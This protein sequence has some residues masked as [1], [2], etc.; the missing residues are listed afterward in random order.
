MKRVPVAST[1]RSCDVCNHKMDIVL[2]MWACKN[3]NHTTDADPTQLYHVAKRFGYELAGYAGYA[4]QAVDQRRVAEVLVNLNQIERTLA[5]HPSESHQS[6]AAPVRGMIQ[7]WIDHRRIGRDVT[8]VINQLRL[9]EKSRSTPDYCWSSRWY[10]NI[11]APAL[12]NKIEILNFYRNRSQNHHEVN[13]A[14]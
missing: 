5:R 2:A 14:I 8:N 13:H 11:M 3:C 4:E 7:G 6:Y 10:W 1:T 12:R 9:A